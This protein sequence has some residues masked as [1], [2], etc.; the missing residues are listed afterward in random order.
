VWTFK[1]QPAEDNYMVIVY[2][3]HF[4]TSAG[5]DMFPEWF[6]AVKGH[7]QQQSGYIN[8]TNEIIESVSDAVSL[9]VTFEDGPSLDAWIGTREH[10]SVVNGLDQYRSRTY[11][12]AA[13]IECE[14][15]N[16]RL[17]QESEWK[18]ITAQYVAEDKSTPLS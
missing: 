18:K 2:V 11:W 13:R 12:M 3:K 16:P 6:D 10:S 14:D 1:K 17:P 5:K 15:G 9:T 7:M 4:L 8:F